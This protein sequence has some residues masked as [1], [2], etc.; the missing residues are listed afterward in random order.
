MRATAHELLLAGCYGSIENQPPEFTTM[1][2]GQFLPVVPR[3]VKMPLLD[4][5][6]NPTA[7]IKS[8]STLLCQIGF[9]FGNNLMVN[10]PLSVT[11]KPSE[12]RLVRAKRSEI[13][14]QLKYFKD[15]ETDELIKKGFCRRPKRNEQWPPVLAAVQ[16]Q[17]NFPP[18]AEKVFRQ[19]SFI[20]SAALY[21]RSKKRS[22][23]H[24]EWIRQSQQICQQPDG[25]SHRSCGS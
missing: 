25:C 1:L 20:N 7:S 5:T 23:S 13:L 12:F 15:I 18:D 6:E 10:R 22:D 4:E 8:I 2:L 17:S 19:T 11:D 16:W 24:I 3:D 14:E 9:K 21:E